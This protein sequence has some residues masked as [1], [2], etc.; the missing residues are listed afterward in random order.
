MKLL[1][2]G[3]DG[4]L[5]QRLRQTL[6]PLGEV[7]ATTVGGML[8]DGTPCERLDMTDLDAITSTIARIAP[9][10]VVNA[11]AHTAVDKAESEPD[12]A[13]RINGEAPGVVADVCATM[14]ATMVHYSTDYVF[15][16]QGTR[17][18]RE[19][20]PTAP[21]GVY[22]RSKRA[23]EEAVQRSGARHMTSAATPSNA[24]THGTA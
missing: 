22:G 14:G 23:G 6:A 1:L 13:H 3:G 12:L 7:V 24:S 11:T 5:G 16:G 9:D 2:L 21:L 8:A 18:Y 17:P 20:D 15:D 4:Q 19:D 10:V